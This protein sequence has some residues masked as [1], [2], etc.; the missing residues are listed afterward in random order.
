[1]AAS[2]NQDNILDYAGAFKLKVC[3]IIS[4]R[5]SDN[6]EKA[7]RQNI[8][9]QLLAITLIEDVTTPVLSGTIDVNDG[10]EI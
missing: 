6:S 2:D 3:N 5:K 1:M 10:V 8:L 9:P 7:V 4:Y